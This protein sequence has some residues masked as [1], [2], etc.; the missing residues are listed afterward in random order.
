MSL[1]TPSHFAPPTASALTLDPT[2]ALESDSLSS[3]SDA[4]A[5]G[6]QNNQQT[7]TES[8]TQR[9]QVLDQLSGDLDASNRELKEQV[10]L[11][12][13]ELAVSRTA[14][15]RELAEK[16]RLFARL[17][18]LLAVLPGGI[19]LLDSAGNV[20]DANPAA[21][22]LLGEP[23]FT[24]AWQAVV[25]RNPEMRGDQTT[26]RYLSVKTRRL[27]SQDEELVLI[28]D[29]TVNRESQQQQ[30][31]R[32]RLAAMG[33]MAARLAHQIRTPLAAT[34]LYLGQLAQKELST[35][36]R[37]SIVSRLSERLAHM[38]ALIESMLG[39][40]RGRSAE[41]EPVAVRSLLKSLEQTARPGLPSGVTLNITPV[42][43]TLRISG[44][45]DE[46][47]G[48]LVNLVRNAAELEQKTL[49]I[50][51]WAGATSPDTMQF[52]I[53]DNGP[54]I[55]DDVLPRLFDPFFTTRAKGTG[56]GLAVVAMTA[57]QHEGQV[58]AQNRPSG[59]A[60]FLIDLPLIAT[61]AGNA[62]SPQ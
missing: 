1:S 36:D 15:L 33:E 32:Q 42:D 46:L 31:R 37:Q 12:R 14:R 39:F 24:E 27:S 8:H 53:S 9:E 25:D 61:E 10:A 13:A 18:S 47:V 41:R 11:L 40:I 16:E 48:A 23:L 28:T 52:R 22:E 21:L 35:G 44:A 20:R 56:L 58:R 4:G 59:G 7:Q 19:V 45:A 57:A 55:A 51:V 50:D 62:G 54:G 3:P 6:A 60:E 2:L 30:G 38:E 43:D 29:D 17:S 49:V 5:G 26:G 34:T